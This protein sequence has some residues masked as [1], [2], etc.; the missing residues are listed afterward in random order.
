MRSWDQLDVERDSSTNFGDVTFEVYKSM[1]IFG[2]KW[3]EKLGGSPASTVAIE[4]NMD[5]F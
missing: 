4:L 3:R 5:V 2:V 1:F